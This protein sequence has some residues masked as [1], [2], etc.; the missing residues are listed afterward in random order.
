MA[1]IIGSVVGAVVFVICIPICVIYGA[2]CRRGRLQRLP[3]EGITKNITTT[4]IT[5]E[6]G[7][8]VVIEEMTARLNSAP[9]TQSNPLYQ[10]VGPPSDQPA[11]QPPPYTETPTGGPDVGRYNLFAAAPRTASGVA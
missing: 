8:E 11:E 9:V 2:I 10:P 7:T 4:V 6:D 1:V 3:E 5:R